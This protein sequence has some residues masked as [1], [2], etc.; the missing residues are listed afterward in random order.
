MYHLKTY[1]DKIIQ[2]FYSA[3]AGGKTRTVYETW[4]GSNL[5]YLIPVEDK[6]TKNDVRFGHGVGMSQVGAI[7]MIAYDNAD[8]VK[9][10]T[11][12]YNGVEVERLY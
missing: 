7:R 4:G 12:Y 11:Y 1:N 5:P 9:V 10:L 8:F 3:N 6:Y 2:A